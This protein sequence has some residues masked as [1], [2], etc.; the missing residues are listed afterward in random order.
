MSYEQSRKLI[1][2][3][4][5]VSTLVIIALCIYWYRLGIFTSQEKMSAYLADKKIMGPFVFILIQIIQ[6]VIPI[7]PGG[8]SLLAG[9][10]FFGAGPGFIYNYVGIVLG[11][12]INFFLARY[13]GR[14]FILHIVSEESLEK[15]TK[16]TKNQK[17]FNWF[18]AVCILAPVAPDDLLCLLAGLTE[19]KPWTYFWIIVLCKPWTI[20]AYSL[21]LVYGARW[22][23][24]LVN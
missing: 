3:L 2:R 14:S 24:R 20:A 5:I 7:I 16:W 1:N 4:T 22:L 18:F 21:G 11:S 23:M 19:M 13:Y 15:Y 8:V 9:V 12:L 17:K 10:V 6:V